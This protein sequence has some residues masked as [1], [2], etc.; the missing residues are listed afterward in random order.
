M[1]IENLKQSEGNPRS[2]R[3]DRFR[4][5]KES[6]EK[7]S[8]FLELRPIIYDPDTMEIIAGNMKDGNTGGNSFWRDEETALK[9]IAYLKKKWGKWINVGQQKTK[10]RLTLRVKRQQSIKL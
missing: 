9:E 2:I 8:K 7:R 4:D 6:I 1:K 5:L 10:R 3:T